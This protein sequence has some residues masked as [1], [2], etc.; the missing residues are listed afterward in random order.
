MSRSSAILAS[1]LI[2]KYNLD[3]ETCNKLLKKRRNVVS[4]NEGFEKE[5]REYSAV[6]GQI[7]K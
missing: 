3:F 4:I 1:Y 2:K 6:I 5:L 7:N